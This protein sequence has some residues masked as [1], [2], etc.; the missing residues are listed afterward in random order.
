MPVETS[1]SIKIA[2][3][4]GREMFIIVLMFCNILYY[5]CFVREILFCLY[6]AVIVATSLMMKAISRA[7]LIMIISIS[8]FV[9]VLILVP[10]V[11]L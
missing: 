7:I 9:M 5:S 10:E 4:L 6:L 3:G 8:K 1:W 2:M 11:G